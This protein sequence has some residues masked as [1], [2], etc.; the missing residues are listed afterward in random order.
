MSTM[1]FKNQFK[2]DIEFVDMT[3]LDIL[4][5]KIKENTKMIIIESPTNP[6]MKILD[7]KGICDIA[8]AQ[9]HK[10]ITAVD[11]T[12]ASPYNQTPL[13]LGA[14]ISLNSLTKYIS[15]HSDLMGGSMTFNDKE[16]EERVYSALM[17]KV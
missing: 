13:E 16:L 2:L 5:A 6:T 10:I 9:D 8:K 15:G 14:D 7:I 12:F 3:D 11:N 1:I 17:S 4:K